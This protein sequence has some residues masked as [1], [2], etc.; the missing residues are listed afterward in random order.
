MQ[1]GSPSHP[2]ER[3]KVEKRKFLSSWKTD[4]PWV[5]D[6]AHGCDVNNAWMLGKRMPL[7]KAVIS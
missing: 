5:Y 6:S 3:P 4:F 1:I 2:A 7:L